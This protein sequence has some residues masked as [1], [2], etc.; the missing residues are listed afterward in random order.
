MTTTTT[1]IGI[2]P[3]LRKAPRAKRTRKPP[4]RRATRK[5]KTAR[6][7]RS[8][9]SLRVTRVTRR[10]RKR[11]KRSRRRRPKR[12]RRRKQR[13][14]RRRKRRRR[15]KKP[16]RRG[17]QFA[18]LL[19]DSRWHSS[20][21]APALLCLRKRRAPGLQSRL[22]AEPHLRQQGRRTGGRLC[23]AAVCLCQVDRNSWAEMAQAIRV[24]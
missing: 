11:R 15:R 9:A 2:S 3:R 18:R 5:G 16:R 8:K 17:L 21:E 14:L 13:K 6:R 24:A 1:T 19:A 12:R 23:A 10:R 7:S 22:A 4:R 20:A